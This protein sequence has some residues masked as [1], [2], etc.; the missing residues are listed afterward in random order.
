MTLLETLKRDKVRWL[1][2]SSPHYQT[3]RAEAER[4]AAQGLI[5]MSGDKLEINKETK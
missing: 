3:T 4:L 2:T 1:D 5:K